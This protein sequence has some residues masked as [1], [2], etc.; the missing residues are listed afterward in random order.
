MRYGVQPDWLAQGDRDL[1]T[2][3]VRTQM[4]QASYP[5]SR[6][7]RPYAILWQPGARLL[8]A[9]DDHCETH[10]VITDPVDEYQERPFQ[11]WVRYRAQVTDAQL[12]FCRR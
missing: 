2:H 8:P 11:W 1:A 4:L 5:L 3:L 6:S 7:P 10:V 12:C 9:T